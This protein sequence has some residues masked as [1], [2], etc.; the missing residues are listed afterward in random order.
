MKKRA[1]KSIERTNLC[2]YPCI[3]VLQ[4][5]NSNNLLYIYIF[6]YIRKYIHNQLYSIITKIF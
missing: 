6:Y 5:E 1:K 4:W 3:F 2:I